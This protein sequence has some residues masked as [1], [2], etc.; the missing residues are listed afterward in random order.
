MSRLADVPSEDHAG[1]APAWHTAA[2]VV[3]ILLVAASGMLLATRAT[4]PPAPPSDRIATLYLPVAFVQMGLSFYVVRV[5]RASSA[6]S[7]LLGGGRFSAKGALADLAIAGALWA[8]VAAA[9]VIG[10]RFFRATGAAEMGALL[11]ASAPERVAWAILA[12][13]VGVTEELVYR[14]YL[15]VQLAAFTRSAPLGIALQALLFG[16]AHLNQGGRMAVEI[17]LDGAVFGAVAQWRRG[18]AACI[19]CHVFTD[20]LAGFAH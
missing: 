8:W 5:G 17:A 7:R 3:L 2:L 13:L 10:A 18:L 11:P 6:L 9:G 16:I 1:L 4:P 12:I 19:A 14:G 20:L 15:R